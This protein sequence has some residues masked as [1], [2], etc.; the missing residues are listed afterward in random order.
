VS[1]APC[2]EGVCPSLDGEPRP[3]CRTNEDCEHD[4]VC[5][6]TYVG[7][8]CVSACTTPGAPCAEHG[9]CTDDR[10]CR[11]RCEPG[12]FAC[13]GVGICLTTGA[14]GAG[15]CVPSCGGSDRGCACDPERGACLSSPTIGFWVGEACGEAR[16]CRSE[17]CF[18]TRDATGEPTGFDAGYCTVAGGRPDAVA[19]AGATVPRSNCPDNAAAAVAEF[20]PTLPDAGPEATYC[21][22]R[23]ASEADCREGY[24]CDHG[25]DTTGAP[26]YTDG[27]CT[28][29]GC[30]TAD[31]C[32]TGFRCAP[33]GGSRRVA[34]CVRTE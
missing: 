10:L 8:V 23:C 5:L 22:R 24:R 19:I 29:I 14:P 13:G 26:R 30:A 27:V 1:G 25:R 11:P 17:R 15:V 34:V 33:P 16:A 31:D 18:P 21:A 9:Y 32:P 7:G 3:L 12:A 20:F 6:H 4:T 28:P 2:V